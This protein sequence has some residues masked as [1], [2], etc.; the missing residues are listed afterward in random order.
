MYGFSKLVA[1]YPVRNI[2]SA[3]VCNKLEHNHFMTNGVP[4]SLVSDNAKVIKSK[5][6]SNFCF[7][8]GI[9]RIN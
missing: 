2:T 7:Q 8:W 9:K 3:V 4:K 1:F 6:F 5:L